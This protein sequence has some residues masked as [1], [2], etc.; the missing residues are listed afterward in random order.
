M[1]KIEH[2]SIFSKNVVARA[3]YE[4]LIMLPK[5]K[6]QIARS[7]AMSQRQSATRCFLKQV[8]KIPIFQLRVFF[9]ILAAQRHCLKILLGKIY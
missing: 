8:P 3:I 2:L 6:M 9:T 5:Q 7:V 4:N 1:I